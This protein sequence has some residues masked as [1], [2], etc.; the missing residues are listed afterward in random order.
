MGIQRPPHAPS[1]TKTLR[2][3]G[4]S[5][6]LV[7]AALAVAGLPPDTLTDIFAGAGLVE[8]AHGTM[9]PPDPER[10]RLN[11]S[12]APVQ[13]C[14]S[15]RTGADAPEVRILLDPFFDHA[16]EERHRRSLALADA[17]VR[18]LGWRDAVGWC[19]PLVPQPLV[20]ALWIG[21]RL[22][23]GT[24]PFADGVALYLNAEAMAETG[25]PVWRAMI[26][27]LDCLL[28]PSADRAALLRRL[29]GLA[30]CVSLA[31]EVAPAPHPPRV[32]L[33]LRAPADTATR[34]A[35]LLA[36][37]QAEPALAILQARA[38]WPASGLTL[39]LSFA[40]GSGEP[41]GLKL[42]VCLCPDCRRVAGVSPGLDERLRAQIPGAAPVLDAG[43]LALLGTGM[44]GKGQRLNIYVEPA[45]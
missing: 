33:Y 19:A 18:G 24:A 14:L 26:G 42:D 9:R 31:L 6:I 10:S 22:S 17:L 37:G 35:D 43:R 45:T 15:R 1:H 34:L 27:A 39:G 3:C 30:R 12:G 32:K 28:P 40:S 8:P 13:V 5:D 25:A 38:A 20:G 7:R 2:H 4:P 44:G 16:P 11:R 41:D 21:G 23:R 36:P 29:T